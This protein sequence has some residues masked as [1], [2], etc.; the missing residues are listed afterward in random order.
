MSEEEQE[1][2]EFQLVQALYSAGVPFS[3]VNNP[4]VIQF[5]Q[6][7]RPAFKLPNRKKLADDLLDDVYDEVKA[8]A[9]E[10]ISK[11]KSLCM[12]SDGWSN[13]N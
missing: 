4:L 12:I 3:F 5:F 13:I 11:A 8:Q 10:Q 7:L 9:D 6:H 2:L 1:D